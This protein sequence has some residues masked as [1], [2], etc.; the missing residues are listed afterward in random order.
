MLLDSINVSHIMSFAF[1]DLVSELSRQKWISP[2]QIAQIFNV[3]RM[4]FVGKLTL[5]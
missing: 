5:K 3:A 4:C 2:I 1:C